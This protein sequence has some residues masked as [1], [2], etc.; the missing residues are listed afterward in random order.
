M[1]INIQEK[2]WQQLNLSSMA[3]PEVFRHAVAIGVAPPGGL[4]PALQRCITPYRRCSHDELMAMA[5]KRGILPKEAPT[6]AE[7]LQLLMSGPQRPLIITKEGEAVR[8]SVTERCL[9]AVETAFLEARVEEEAKR[10]LDWAKRDA[11]AHSD[12]ALLVN[13]MQWLER[14]SI[15]AGTA[16]EIVRYLKRHIV[17]FLKW[18][19][20]LILSSH[21][22]LEALKV[23]CKLSVIPVADRNVLSQKGAGFFQ[24]V[25]GD[26]IISSASLREPQRLALAALKEGSASL[27]GNASSTRSSDGG[28]NEL[29]CLMQLRFWLSRVLRATYADEKPPLEDGEE[30][31]RALAEFRAGLSPTPLMVVLPTG[32]GKSG[33]MCGAPFAALSNNNRP[34]RVLV[35]CPS[36][37]IREQMASTFRTFYRDRIGL[38]QE[39]R[40]LEIV[41]SP[42]DA[43][44]H[45][46]YDVYVITFHLLAGNALIEHYPRNFFDLVLVDEAHHAE[47]ST[48]RLLREHFFSTQFFYFTGTPYR[49]DHQLLRANA[50]FSC[51]MKDALLR[52]DPYIKHVC[53][54][55]VPVERLTL[56][57]SNSEVTFDSFDSIVANSREIWP[58]LRWSM[59]AKAQVIGRAMEKLRGLRGVSGIHH[60]AILHAENSEDAHFLAHLWRSHPSNSNG[61]LTIDVVES[62]LDRKQVEVVIARLKLHQLDAIVHVGMLGE[63]FDHPHLSVCCVFRRFRSMAPFIQFIGRVLRR[64][65]APS[66]DSDNVAYVVAHPGLGLHK[67]WK[68]YKQED[69]LPDSEEL[70]VPPPSS[71]WTDIY[72]TV[73]GA[74]GTSK[75]EWFLV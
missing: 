34:G 60:Q 46:D 67:L 68:L 21:G 72:N 57:S 6:S 16:A 12:H 13:R 15:G 11:L 10:M 36:I 22:C 65:P 53:Y 26:E 35:V 71:N 43:K 33:V 44:L 64:I 56:K 19:K 23:D 51:S 74:D 54:S 73:I 69:E 49:S 28:S 32:V 59:E 41:G 63:G 30:V 47:A 52:Q 48:Y 39:P 50:V 27:A 25:D 70:V 5:M 4:T 14:L 18:R 20:D 8:R 38:D 66:S 3:K 31:F 40:L 2:D 1:M 45:A 55:P 42:F 9:E 75:E 17:P 37:A 61:S 29:S 58:A 7:L 24:T 62:S